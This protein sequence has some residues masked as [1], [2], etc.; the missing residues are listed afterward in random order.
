MRFVPYRVEVWLESQD[1]VESWSFTLPALNFAPASAV[2]W[3]PSLQRGALG[4]GPPFP[5][6]VTPGVERTP[7]H[8]S[9]RELSLGTSP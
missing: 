7:T 3:G 2:S 6:P 5:T 4:R 8:Q 1:V 9:L